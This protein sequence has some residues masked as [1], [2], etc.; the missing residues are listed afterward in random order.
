[1]HYLERMSVMDTMKR[2]INVLGTELRQAN[3]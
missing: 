3:G 2:R 1:M